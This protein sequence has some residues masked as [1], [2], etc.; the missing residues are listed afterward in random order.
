MKKT[1]QV[2]LCGQQFTVRSDADPQEVFRVAAFVNGKI[3]DVAAS[4]KMVDT[5]HAS[6]LALL[7]V[8]G[9]YLRLKEEQQAE[10]RVCDE[11]LTLLLERLDAVLDGG[12]PT[13]EPRL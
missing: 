7:N 13:E 3:N 8:A 2:T 6:M 5:L 4:G 9:D 11:R 12:T 1:V 10:G